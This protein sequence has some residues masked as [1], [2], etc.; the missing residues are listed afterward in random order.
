M[1]EGSVLGFSP[2]F[3]DGHLLAVSSQRPSFVPVSTS[4]F[5]LKWVPVILEL[6]LTLM[7]SFYLF[8]SLKIL[9]LNTGTL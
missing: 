7:T 8:T 1:R 5:S 2:W 3:V 9:S 6:E 4:Q